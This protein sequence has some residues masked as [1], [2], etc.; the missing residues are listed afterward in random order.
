MAENKNWHLPHFCCLKDDKP[1]GGNRYMMH[2]DQPF[3]IHCYDV[4]HSPKCQVRII[5][6][7]N[8]CVVCVCVCVCVCAAT[9]FI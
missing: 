4:E 3:C 1:L 2:E 8:V 9:S 5:H 7:H 6:V